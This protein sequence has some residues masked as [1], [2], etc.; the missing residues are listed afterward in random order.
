[1][2]SIFATLFLTQA[3][4]LG[5]I[6]HDGDLDMFFDPISNTESYGNLSGRVG[7]FKR[8]KSDKVWGKKTLS[9]R[10]MDKFV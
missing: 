8:T 9:K 6:D 4:F 5:I 10:T 2:G 3:S 1:M 7:R